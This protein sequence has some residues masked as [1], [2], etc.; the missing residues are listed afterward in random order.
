MEGIRPDFSRLSD[1]KS[2]DLENPDIGLRIGVK[3]WLLLIL[4]CVF[5][6]AFAPLMICL[7]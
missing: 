5:S 1:V 4:G 7:P 2:I 6:S 3:E